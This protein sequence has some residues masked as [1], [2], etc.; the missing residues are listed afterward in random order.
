MQRFLHMGVP[1]LLALLIAGAA[2]AEDW[3]LRRDT[4][5]SACRVELA[6]APPLGVIQIA[7]PFPSRGDACNAALDQYDSSMSD[8]SKCWS[9]VYQTINWCM[10]E[11]VNLPR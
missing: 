7:G 4:S 10:G 2:R 1:A 5:S 3:V 11:G 9:Y 6:A 8:P